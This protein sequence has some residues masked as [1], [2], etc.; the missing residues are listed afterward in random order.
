MAMCM[1]K[2]VLVSTY[3]VKRIRK[4]TDFQCLKVPTGMSLIQ[5]SV[6]EID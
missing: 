5:E 6:V 3:A 2:A 1:H 4:R